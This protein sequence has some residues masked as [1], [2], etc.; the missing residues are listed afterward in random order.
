[1]TNPTDPRPLRAVAESEP[2]GSSAMTSPRAGSA[3][4][5]DSTRPGTGK[6]SRMDIER[7]A[8]TADVD[9]IDEECP[10]CELREAIR[11]AL[12]MVVV[13]TTM[14]LFRAELIE[15]VDQYGNWGW[16]GAGVGAAMLLDGI[17]SALAWLYGAGW[18]LWLHTRPVPS[19]VPG[20][21]F[22]SDA[23]DQR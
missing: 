12:A 10:H 13:L 14:W 23:R 22:P 1:M 5:Q 19:W 15:L 17:V 6:E 16:F 18:A 8:W 11:A 21:A 9:P 2:G 3:N 20:W 7:L 4:H